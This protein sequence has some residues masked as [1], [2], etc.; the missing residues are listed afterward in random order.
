M[1]TP[2]VEEII[3]R[4]RINGV[5]LMGIEVRCLGL[6]EDSQL[7]TWLYVSA[8]IDTNLYYT[9]RYRPPAAWNRRPCSRRRS[10]FLQPRRNSMGAGADASSG[11]PDHN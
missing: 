4:N 10:L 6:Y 5:V 8:W 7:T 11:G 3:Q 1:I 2:E 9:N